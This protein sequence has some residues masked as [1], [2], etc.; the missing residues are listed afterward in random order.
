MGGVETKMWRDRAREMGIS[1]RGAF[2]N[3]K[4]NWGLPKFTEWK[5]GME[6]LGRSAQ[7]DK[8]CRDLLG[9]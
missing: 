8:K 6:G 7:G 5:P 1:R 2:M 9:C 3:E 4:E